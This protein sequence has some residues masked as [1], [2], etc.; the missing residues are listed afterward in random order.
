MGFSELTTDQ[1]LNKT[2]AKENQKDIKELSVSEMP[3]INS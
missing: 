3:M 1:N 2:D